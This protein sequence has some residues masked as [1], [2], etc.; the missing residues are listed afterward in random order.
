MYMFSKLFAY[1]VVLHA[2]VKST[3]YSF[4]IAI[5][6]KQLGPDQ[7]RQYVGP[8]LGPSRLQWLSADDITRQSVLHSIKSVLAFGR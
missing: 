2:F 5:S 4:R 1:C 8:N 7:T 6:V 3:L